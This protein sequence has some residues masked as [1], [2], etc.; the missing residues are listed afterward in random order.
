MV[1]VALKET[2]E[3]PAGTVTVTGIWRL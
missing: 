1:A 2:E 3:E